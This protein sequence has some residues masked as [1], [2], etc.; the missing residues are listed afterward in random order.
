MDRPLRILHLEDSAVDAEIVKADLESAGLK[1]DIVRVE[2]EKDFIGALGLKQFDLIISDFSM[3]EYNGRDAMLYAHRNYPATPFIFVSGTVGEDYA[4]ESLLN[5]AT[6]Y[7]LKT[8]M[9]RLVP[10]VKRAV[11]ENQERLKNIEAEK[12]LRERDERFRALLENSMDGLV[13]FNQ[14]GDVTSRSPA[15]VRILGQDQYRTEGGNIFDNIHPDD[16]QMVRSKLA[17]VGSTEGAQGRLIFRNRHGDGTWRLLE[18]T[19]SNMISDPRVNGIVSN[20][21]DVTERVEAE[22]VLRQAQKMESLGTLA[23]GIAHDFNNILGII[24]GYSSFISRHPGDS[25][26]LPQGIAIIQKAA[27]RGVGLVR[28][29]L[30]FAR[31]EESEFVPL[32]VNE[33]VTEAFKLVSETFPRVI[34]AEL[35]IDKDLPLVVGDHV[36]I[37][38]CLLNLCVNARDA[39]MDRKDGDPS[40]GKLTI[41]TRM[42]DESI[43]RSHAGEAGDLPYVAVSVSDTG[44]GMAPA[45]VVRI[46]EPFFT[47]KEKGKGT[48]IG[49]ATVFGIMKKHGGF[50]DVTTEIGVGSTFTLLLPASDSKGRAEEVEPVGLAA[51]NQ[52]NETVLV[53]E[54]EETLRE[55]LRDTLTDSGY[56]VLTARD[57]NEALLL[58]S[59]NH[60]ISLVLSDVGL[61]VLD[62]IEVLSRIKLTRPDLRVILASGFVEPETRD[63]MERSHAD[64]FIQKP[65]RIV[66]VLEKV[67]RALDHNPR[68]DA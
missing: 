16:V 44:T 30:T 64:G 20:F 36:Q 14:Q 17:A 66:D 26:K 29:L 15:N 60:D 52:G 42:A 32:Q 65:Y 59:Q 21:R 56:K 4:I 8:K 13:V 63:K 9:S 45:T 68:T 3:P 38:Q 49:L 24:I 25:E 34:K 67:R 46:F 31:K 22:S 62:G 12:T 10:A 48:G 61:P 11:E 37:N 51:N 55:L 50:V 54:D 6:D 33:I 53:A 47:T 23:S 18:A 58:V 43:L 41:T 35:V 27:E 1:C 2:N 40:G 28:Q 57:G 5:G 7:V 19:F 39:M